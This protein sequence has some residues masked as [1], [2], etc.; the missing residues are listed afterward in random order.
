MQNL[1]EDSLAG[2][3]RGTSNHILSS[4][5]SSHEVRRSA[6]ACRVLVY[7]H[8]CFMHVAFLSMQRQHMLNQYIHAS[9]L[10]CVQLL[11]HAF[12]CSVEPWRCSHRVQPGSLVSSQST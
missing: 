11:S 2:S 12:A 5:P 8:V 1:P 10:P 3:K 6:L 4:V 7:M 9:F